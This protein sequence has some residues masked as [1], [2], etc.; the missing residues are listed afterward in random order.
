M[1]FGRVL[2]RCG[3]VVE[4]EPLALQEKLRA[5]HSTSGRALL[6]LQDARKKRQRLLFDDLPTPPFTGTRVIE[7]KISTLREYIDWT[8]F[9]TAWELKGKYPAIL[10]SPSHAAVARDLF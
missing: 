1:E 9:F 5:Q 6:T 8:F 4:E 7:P 10:D 3:Q 2:F